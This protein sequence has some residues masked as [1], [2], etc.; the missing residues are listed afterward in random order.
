MIQ[1]NLTYYVSSSTS[2]LTNSNNV[3]EK[4]FY[5]SSCSISGEAIS[6]GVNHSGESAHD[7]DVTTRIRIYSGSYVVASLPY[8][9]TNYFIDS[10]SN[11]YGT[12]SNTIEIIYKI[13][14]DNTNIDTDYYFKIVNSSSLEENVN[15]GLLPGENI[16]NIYLTSSSIYSIELYAGTNKY[17]YI[18]VNDDTNTLLYS[19]SWSGSQK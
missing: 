19:S 10:S 14:S 6:T 7:H 3:I 5:N 1:Q 15:V 11:S 12:S 9:K 17:N 18:Y 16:G 4:I 2:V 8:H 13:I